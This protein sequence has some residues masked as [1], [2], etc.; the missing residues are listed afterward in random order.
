MTANDLPPSLH[1]TNDSAPGYHL[2]TVGERIIYTDNN[3]KEVKSKAILKRINQLTIPPQWQSVWICKDPEGH[4][5]AV[6]RDAKG[7]KQY[8]Y[9]SFWND[10]ISETKYNK[11]Q[12]FA[13]CLPKIREQVEKDLRKRTWTKEKVLALAIRLMDEL[14]LRVGNKKY[15]KE[16]QTYGLTTLRKKHIKEEKNGL[17]IQYKAKSGKSR[18]LNVSHPTLKRLL[19]QCSEL[20]GYEL[21]KYHSENGFVPIDSRDINTYLRRVSG[22]DI[23]AKTFRTW[24]GTVS[25]VELV[26]EAQ[27]IVEQNPRKKLDTALIGLVAKRLNNTVSVCRKYYIHPRVLNLL[28]DGSEISKAIRTRA[29]KWMSREEKMVMKL[30]ESAVNETNE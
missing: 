28:I 21:F 26:Y 27:Q 3:D 5:Q 16:N 30:L 18:T 2:K 8:I 15:E 7:R 11:L 10:F 23:T 20:P 19:I 6:G 25:A 17:T 1:Y 9:H 4:I 14:Y 29:S 13:R 22:E 24:G 12:S